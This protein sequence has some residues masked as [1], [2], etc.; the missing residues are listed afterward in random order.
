MTSYETSFSKVVT[1]LIQKLTRYSTEFTSLVECV[2][3]LKSIESILSDSKADPKID[4][5]KLEEVKETCED[6]LKNLNNLERLHRLKYRDKV[7]KQS[8]LDDFRYTSENL[9]DLIGIQIAGLI[10][11]DCLLAMFSFQKTASYSLSE[12]FSFNAN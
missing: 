7:F 5:E 12:F 9:R 4:Q 11:P 2:I 10:E 6:L 1:Q 3:V 8:D